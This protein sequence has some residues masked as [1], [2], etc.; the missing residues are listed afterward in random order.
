MI[1]P[2]IILGGGNNFRRF[3]SSVSKLSPAKTTKIK[4]QCLHFLRSL[5]LHKTKKSR[6][7]IGLHP[8]SLAGREMPGNKSL[9]FHT[10]FRKIPIN[11]INAVIQSDSTPNHKSL[12][13]PQ[14]FSESSSPAQH[15]YLGLRNPSLYPFKSISTSRKT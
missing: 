11:I 8:V 2:V 3:L 5:K 9:D 1:T 10:T 6:Q 4:F 12:W 15:G 14:S 13:L 7:F